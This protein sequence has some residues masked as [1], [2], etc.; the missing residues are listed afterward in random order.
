M[1][2]EEVFEQVKSLNNRLVKDIRAFVG[3][4]FSTDELWA[5]ATSQIVEAEGV[6][7]RYLNTFY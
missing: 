4:D 3:K 7:K 5:F 2:R 1:N 6:K